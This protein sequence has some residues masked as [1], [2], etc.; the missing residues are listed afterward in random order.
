MA[1]A[2]A[3]GP[4]QGYIAAIDEKALGGAT[5][6]RPRASRVSPTGVSR[7]LPTEDSSRAEYARAQG[8]SHPF[9]E[10]GLDSQP[11]CGPPGT[12]CSPAKR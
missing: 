12:G 10:R 9:L 4:A 1:G 5:S 6:A 11:S 3:L 7:P 2:V 8:S